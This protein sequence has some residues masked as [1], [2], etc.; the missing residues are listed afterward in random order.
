MACKVC[1]ATT[2]VVF[3]K[4]LL[5]RYEVTYYQ[6]DRCQFLQTESPYW[7]DEAYNDAGIAALDTG[8]VVRN[9]RMAEQTAQV[10]GRLLPEAGPCLDFGG[11]TGLFVRLM[12]DRGW[13]FYRS[14]RYTE[15]VFARGFDRSDL[16]VDHRF[17]WVTAF[18]V[19]EHLPNPV[20]TLA[21]LLALSDT[22]LFSTDLQPSP[23]SKAADLADW[24]YLLPQTGQHISFYT[25]A[26]LQALA[27]RFDCQVFSNRRDLHL[28]TRKPWRAS[29]V[30]PLLRQP[31]WRRG[32]RW[33]GR[34]GGGRRSLVD[35]DLAKI[36]AQVQSSWV[37]PSVSLG[38]D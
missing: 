12:R 7:L 9:L 5:G 4:R 8:I 15:N 35:P 13:A 32:M 33:L 18:E 28:L 37:G 3:Q 16:P 23:V 27:E 29:Q 14:D 38:R 17:D 26:A 30:E 19:M 6:C 2:T 25:E 20:E 1:G 36:S 24:S 10:L 31:L 22:V 21:E 34:R 11:G